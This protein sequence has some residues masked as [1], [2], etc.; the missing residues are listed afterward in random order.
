M[1]HRLQI[2]L[3]QTSLL[4]E[5]VTGNLSMLGDKINR[6]ENADIILLPESFTTGFSMKRGVAHEPEMVVDWMK[7]MAV[8]KNAAIGGS[9]FAKDGN[10]AFNRFYF[11]T[12]E[13]EVHFYNKKHLFSLTREHEVFNAGN[14]QCIVTYKGWN[15]SLMVCFDLRFPVWMRRTETHNYDLLLLVANWPE[16]RSYAWNQ[17]LIS[18]AIENQSYVA[19]VNRVGMD[20]NEVWH[21]G[22]SLIIDPMGKILSKGRSFT[23]SIIKSEIQLET[24]TKVRN[25]LP[26]YNDGD[27]FSL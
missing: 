13:G 18:R 6:A 14:S 10:Q 23:D 19:A 17:L 27:S 21:A 11:V 9:I 26:F 22:D 12:P 7:E 4:W 5:D 15:I 1:N 2:S 16:R 24:V 20:A 3:I 8:K 25:A